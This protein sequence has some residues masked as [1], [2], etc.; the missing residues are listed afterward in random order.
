MNVKQGEG[1]SVRQSPTVEGQPLQSHKTTVDIANNIEQIHPPQPGNI[2]E[3]HYSA[4][5]WANLEAIIQ[6]RRKRRVHCR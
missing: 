6:I 5:I 3:P 1:A 2:L 4:T